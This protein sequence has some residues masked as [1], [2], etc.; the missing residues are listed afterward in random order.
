LLA[1][2]KLA[3]DAV[4]QQDTLDDESIQKATKQLAICEG[5][6]WFWWFGDAN[7]SGSVSDFDQLFRMQLKNLYN[8][9][10]LPVPT[11]LEEHVSVGGGGAE[12]AGTM[13]RNI[14]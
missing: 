6:D 8:L 9:L 1:D 12:N 13:V 5:S 4:M 11:N 3:F 10:H 14:G 2:A 7:P